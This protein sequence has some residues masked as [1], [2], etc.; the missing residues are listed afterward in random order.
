[1]AAGVF[2]ALALVFDLCVARSPGAWR[3]R[4][5]R[6]DWFQNWAA[7]ADR[8][9]YSSETVSGIMLR[10]WSIVVSAAG[11]L[12]SYIRERALARLNRHLLHEGFARKL[13]LQDHFGLWMLIGVVGLIFCAATNLFLCFYALC[14]IQIATCFRGWRR[15][16]KIQTEEG[17]RKATSGIIED[18]ARDLKDTR[19]RIA[20]NEGPYVKCCCENERKAIARRLAGFSDPTQTSRRGTEKDTG[21]IVGYFSSAL[22]LWCGSNAPKSQ[23]VLT[24]LGRH[25]A[26]LSD[27]CYQ[28][29]LLAQRQN[30]LCSLPDEKHSLEEASKLFGVMQTCVAHQAQYK[31]PFWSCVVDGLVT[32][33]DN[34]EKDAK[35]ASEKMGDKREEDAFEYLSALANHTR[36]I[37]FL[38]AAMTLTM[39]KD[40]LMPD[41]GMMVEEF[42]RWDQTRRWRHVTMDAPWSQGENIF[43]AS[44]IFCLEWL[45]RYYSSDPSAKLLRYYHLAFRPQETIAL[46]D[47]AFDTMSLVA[48]WL[49]ERHC[50]RSAP[51]TPSRSEPFAFFYRLLHVLSH[52]ANL[53]GSAIEELAYLDGSSLYEAFLRADGA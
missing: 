43:R 27:A 36:Y 39:V 13:G 19:C 10:S 51:P 9:F 3:W 4:L 41:G 30:R 42:E 40:T 11:A 21:Q 35:D 7:W 14:I 52:G 16:G 34:L 26:T 23:N 48:D 44:L 46:E 53:R 49:S 8:T 5:R 45:I 31:I 29:A 50:N 2:V 37:G 33:Y 1:V 15:Y 17:L 25:A 12:L 22:A 18:W 20:C 24:D 32:R 47:R 38:I 6:A 28:S